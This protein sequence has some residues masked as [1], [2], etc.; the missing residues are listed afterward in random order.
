MTDSVK[1]MP[2]SLPQ[3]TEGPLVTA[4]AYDGLC[5]FEFG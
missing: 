3:Q 1:I 4:L 2:N 5:T